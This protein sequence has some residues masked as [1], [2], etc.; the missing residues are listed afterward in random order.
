M[1][2]FVRFRRFYVSM[3]CFQF[4]HL[5]LS[6]L[7]I[8]ADKCGISAEVIDVRS[9]APFDYNVIGESIKKRAGRLSLKKVL[10]PAVLVRNWLRISWK[11]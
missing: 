1:L 2:F 6:L 5:N 4:S 9:L 11:D 10:S 3:T 8:C 7:P